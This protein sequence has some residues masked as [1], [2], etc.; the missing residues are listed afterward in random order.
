M[1][2]SM[3]NHNLKFPPKA[4]SP[5]AKKIL[6]ISFFLLLGFFGFT[7]SSFAKE[8]YVN[9][10]TGS[11]VTTYASNDAAHPWATLGRALWGN[12]NKSTPNS[13]QAAQA[14]DIVLVSAGTYS[15]AGWQVPHILDTDS[16]K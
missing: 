11:D 13:G 2:N 3:Q 15:Y 9:G 12:A 1:K 10:A 14:G 8:L 6:L 16:I 5:Q 4:D 7:Q